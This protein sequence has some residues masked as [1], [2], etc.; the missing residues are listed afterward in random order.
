LPNK[1]FAGLP[2]FL[3]IFHAASPLSKNDFI[4]NLV[5]GSPLLLPIDPFFF[6]M[7]SI[8]KVRFSSL[9]TC[10]HGSGGLSVLVRN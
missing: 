4:F 9:L 3:W 7:P 5:T 8:I 10:V 2:E 6:R 1:S